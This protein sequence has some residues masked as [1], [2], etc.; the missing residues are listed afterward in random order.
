M[1]F[2][3]GVSKVRAEH[4]YRSNIDIASHFMGRGLELECKEE[5]VK[6]KVRGGESLEMGHRPRSPV[7]RQVA[8]WA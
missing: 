7:A 1:D 2:G 8:A 6:R 3:R 5:E 4:C